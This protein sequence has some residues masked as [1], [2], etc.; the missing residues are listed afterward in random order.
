MQLLSPSTWVDQRS[1][2]LLQCDIQ[3][4]PAH[5]KTLYGIVYTLYVVNTCL[6]PIHKQKRQP[7]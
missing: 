3:Y 4:L 2:Q 6:T 1:C 5:A 7:I